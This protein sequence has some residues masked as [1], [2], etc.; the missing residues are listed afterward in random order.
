MKRYV[1]SRFLKLVFKFYTEKRNKSIHFNILIFISYLYY[2]FKSKIHSINSFCHL[3]S[4]F[5]E[6]EKHLRTLQFI[7]VRVP[8]L[9]TDSGKDLLQIGCY[10]IPYYIFHLC[11]HHNP[12]VPVFHGSLPMVWTMGDKLTIL[13]KPC[14]LYIWFLVK[15]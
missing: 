9:I 12:H 1:V 14:P 10:V 11:H 15:I 5:K 8:T 7:F 2:Y 3:K 6:K 4:L 13:N